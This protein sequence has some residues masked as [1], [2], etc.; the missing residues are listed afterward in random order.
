MKQYKIITVQEGAMGTLF[1]GASK[2]PRQRIE[3]ELNEH[4]KQGWEF[5]FMTIEQARFLLFWTRE[6]AI[7]V[8]VRQQA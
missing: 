5:Q 8:L 6:S 1:L 2:L 7:I 3:E 4:A